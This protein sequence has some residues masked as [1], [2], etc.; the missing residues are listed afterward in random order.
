MSKETFL[1]LLML[2]VNIMGIFPVDNSAKM[3][4]SRVA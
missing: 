4:I 3:F 1:F 2:L